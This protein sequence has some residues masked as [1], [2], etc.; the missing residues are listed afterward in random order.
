[1]AG[2]KPAPSKRAK[3]A[4]APKTDNKKSASKEKAKPVVGKNSK[5]A[6][7][8]ANAKPAAK[9]PVKSAKPTPKSKARKPASR[10]PAAEAKK[11]D[12][13]MDVQ[14]DAVVDEEK[15]EDNK[16][17]GLEVIQP[18]FPCDGSSA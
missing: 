14:E 2:K 7:P 1:V 10:T 16:M 18:L 5:N 17:N 8:V 11:E 12:E 3:T 4:P 15:E 6:K 9:A 13:V